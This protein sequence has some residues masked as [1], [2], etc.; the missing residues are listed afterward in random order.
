MSRLTRTAV[1]AIASLVA[2]GYPAAHA[3]Q[4]CDRECLIG[5]ADRY[6]AA[7]AAHDPAKAPCF[8][9][10]NGELSPPVAPQPVTSKAARAASA[11]RVGSEWVSSVILFPED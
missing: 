4:S 9:I 6:L 11:D 7:I 5:V 3:A 1:A 8:S 10:S 2:A